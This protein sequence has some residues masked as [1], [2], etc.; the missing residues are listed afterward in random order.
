MQTQDI[1]QRLARVRAEV[2]AA[3][4]SCGRDPAEVTLIAV[5]K[6]HPASAIRMA[7]EAGQRDFGESYAKEFRDKRAGLADLTDLR[8][9]F[10]GHL[11]RNKIKWVVG[12]VALHHA[13]GD[14]VGLDEMARRAWALG[15]RQDV[16]LQVNL[17]NESTKRGCHVTELTDYA[18]VL[19]RSP[20][21][22]WR[23]LMTLPPAGEDASVWFAQ[24]QELQAQLRAEHRAA[25]AAQGADLDVLSMGMSGDFASAIAHGATHIRVGTAIFGLRQP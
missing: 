23:G 19:L 24:L 7:Y 5:S 20:G 14:M 9:H 6:N 1:G 18:E 11:Q 21:V 10:I 22:R 3:C 15:S 8:W 16:L 4:D 17:A 25:L 13:I 12:H 2:I